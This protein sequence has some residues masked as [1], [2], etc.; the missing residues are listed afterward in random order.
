MLKKS[1][2]FITRPGGTETQKIDD[3]NSI[4]KA[5]D[6][7]RRKYEPIWCLNASMLAGKQWESYA[8]DVRRY[9][10]YQLHAPGTKIKIVSNQILPLARQ[11]ASSL[12][13]NI[14]QPVTVS[15][16]S[17]PSDI[18]AADVG[19]A[20]LASRM[21]EDDE[22]D[23]RF[24]ELLWSMTCGR[25]AR[26][27]IWDPDLPSEIYGAGKTDGVG[28]LSSLTI[29]PLN[30]HYCPWTD[31][32]EESPWVIISFVKSIEEIN[33]TYHSDVQEEE[34]ADSTRMLDSL[35]LNVVE[36]QSMPEKRKKAAILK[37]L[38]HRPTKE[39]PQGKVF[40]WANGKL[41]MET[42]LPEGEL[43]LQNFDWFP[44]P[45]RIYPLSF[46]SPLVPLQREVNTIMSQLVELK[47]RQLRGDMAIRGYGDVIQKYA[48]VEVGVDEGGYPLYEDTQQKVVTIPSTVQ[49]M[50]FMQYNLNT[51]EA[52]TILAHLF[53]DML[54]IA[55]IHESSL[56]KQPAHQTT[57]TQV[58]ML[59]ESDLAGL[60]IF[61]ASFDN[62][63]CKVAR[64]KLLLAKNHYELPRVVRVVGEN[65]Q[66]K[67][68]AFMGSNLRNT[69]DVRPRAT[70]LVSETMKSQM[71]AESAAQGLYGPYAGPKDKL[72]KLT[73]LLNSG[74]PDI[75]EEVNALLGDQTIEELRA[76]VAK[77]DQG[78]AELTILNQQLQMVS[79]QAQIQAIVSPP[80]PE[81]TGEMTIPGAVAAQ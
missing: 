74:I 41:L 17:D 14:A 59:K 48:R 39:N 58:A 44:I 1:F 6:A 54:Q 65:F 77:L 56:G 51:T 33:D 38:Y 9:R 62:A 61:R 13:E 57:A 30:I 68:R 63:H 60:T 7:A 79:I 27:S 24:I 55:G 23:K 75:E 4:Y 50:Q 78:D 34:V 70:P 16:T 47:N 3:L 36:G 19:T 2:P 10:G 52:E 28:D 8:E 53:N 81:E 31:C 46:I 26:M 5:A 71:K 45:G 72:A 12:R 35:L 21:S 49:D 40:H 15:A 43:L 20:F 67:V 11:A 76:L 73:A 25:V 18:A 37:M 29:K 42:E 80:Q 66:S 22:T 69:E 64:H 32:G